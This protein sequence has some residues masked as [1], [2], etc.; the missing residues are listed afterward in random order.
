MDTISIDNKNRAVQMQSKAAHKTE[1]DLQVI[2]S[3][4]HSTEVQLPLRGKLH[5]KQMIQAFI[6]TT[7]IECK[8]KKKSRAF[9]KTRFQMTGLSDI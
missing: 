1:P 8:L 7:A 9:F 3:L 5:N 2:T 4:M 6:N